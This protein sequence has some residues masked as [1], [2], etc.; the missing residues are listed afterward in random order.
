M[1]VSINNSEPAAMLPFTPATTVLKLSNVPKALSRTG[2]TLRSLRVH[3]VK[4]FETFRIFN[5]AEQ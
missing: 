3:I 5:V 2:A 4:M 1:S